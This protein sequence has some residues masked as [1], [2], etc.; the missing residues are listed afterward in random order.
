MPVL[1][2]VFY[3]P[4]NKEELIAKIPRILADV[5]TLDIEDSVPP[6][7]KQK[8]REL[9]HKNLKFA[10]SSGADVYV[11]I[12]NWETGMTNADCEAVVD[13]GL[14]AVCLAKCGGADHVKRLAWK[15][16]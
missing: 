11:R 15:L 3:V 13:E 1:R 5:I 4:G 2:S 7:E 14:T 10:A 6:A 9:S 8:A 16:G 12:N